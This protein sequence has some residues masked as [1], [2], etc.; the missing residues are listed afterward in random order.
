MRMCIQFVYAPPYTFISI[1]M[2]A[3]LFS[4]FHASCSSRMLP[5]PLSSFFLPLSHPPLSKYSSHPTISRI[6]IVA[7]EIANIIVR[8]LN[9]KQSLLKDD[10]EELKKEV[11]NSE[12]VQK[13]V[14]EDS[15]ELWC[16]AAED[17]R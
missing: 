2:S 12:G 8:A 5:F 14:T 3:Y 7:F 10:I 4:N 17:K 6:D 11:L 1:I 13:L 15:Y 9:L 16:I